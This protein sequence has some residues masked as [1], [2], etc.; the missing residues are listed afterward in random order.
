MLNV[1][2]QSLL[3]SMT[4]SNNSQEEDQ[5]SPASAHGEKNENVPSLKPSQLMQFPGSPCISRDQGF[6]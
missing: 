6:S 5:R 2:K 4:G 3:K 1:K